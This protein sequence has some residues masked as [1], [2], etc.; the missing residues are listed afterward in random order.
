MR[1][2]I[3][4]V[5]ELLEEMAVNAYQWPFEL[6]TLRKTLG[7]HEF[8]VLTTLSS[9]AVSLSKQVSLL[10]AQANIIITPTKAC[11]LYGGPHA[12]T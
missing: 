12:S 8:D 6:N 5:Y 2:N 7:V 3:E 10:T 9:Q 4:D 11:D 1:K